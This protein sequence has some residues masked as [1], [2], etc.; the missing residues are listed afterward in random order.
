MSYEVD[1]ASK[2]FG[3]Y[4]S[5][6]NHLTTH[7]TIIPVEPSPGIIEEFSEWEAFESTGEVTEGQAHFEAFHEFH[8]EKGVAEYS[9]I[10]EA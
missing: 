10:T 9:E 3:S 7:E 5:F 6:C 1:D 2:A 8:E 4:D